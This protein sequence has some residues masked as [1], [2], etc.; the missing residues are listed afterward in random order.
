MLPTLSGL[1]TDLLR[2][3]SDEQLGYISPIERFLY[4][5]TDVFVNIQAD[6]NT[7]SLAEIDPPA[8]SCV[9]ARAGR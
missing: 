4:E 1:S 9:N 2:H 3:G 7:K 6:T 5:Q 8:N